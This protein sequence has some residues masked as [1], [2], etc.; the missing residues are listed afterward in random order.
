M[1]S[2]V[3]MVYF[4]ANAGTCHGGGMLAV[5]KYAHEKGIPDETCNNY[6]VIIHRVFT[7]KSVAKMWALLS[8]N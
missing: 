4:L 2:K 5:Y 8:K 6:Q 7:L 3:S 1:L